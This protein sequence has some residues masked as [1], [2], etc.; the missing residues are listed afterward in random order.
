MRYVDLIVRSGRE[1]SK[2]EPCRESDCKNSTSENKPFCIDHIYLN[3]TYVADLMSEKFD[4]SEEKVIGVLEELLCA[5]VERICWLASM[6][7]REV[8]KAVKSLLAKNQIVENKVFKPRKKQFVITY[9]KG[10]ECSI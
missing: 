4:T 5:S 1:A 3:S 8:N 7:E 2:K 6:T 10:F 9:S